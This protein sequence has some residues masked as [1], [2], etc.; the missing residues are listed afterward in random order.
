MNAKFPAKEKFQEMFRMIIY[1]L[2]VCL[3]Y[4]FLQND[5]TQFIETL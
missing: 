2:K 1:Q 4:N 3:T 5:W